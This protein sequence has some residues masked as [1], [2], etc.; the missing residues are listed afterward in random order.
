MGNS[1]GEQIPEEMKV[2]A[3]LE[4]ETTMDEKKRGAT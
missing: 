2:A 4:Q 1:C 3:G